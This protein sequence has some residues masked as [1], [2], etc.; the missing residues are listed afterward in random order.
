M[1][2]PVH[3]DSPFLPG[4]GVSRHFHPYW[5]GMATLARATGGSE[6]D[7]IHLGAYFSLAVLA[8]GIYAFGRSYYRSSWG[9]VALLSAMLLAWL[10]PFGHT[11]LHSIP[12]LF[13]AAAYPATLLI[14]L[15]LILW[16]L[17]IT[18]LSRMWLAALAIPLVAF[19]FATHQLGAG[20]GLVGAGAILAFW[21]ECPLQAASHRRGSHS[22]RAC[23]VLCLA[24][25]QSL[26]GRPGGRQSTVAGAAEFLQ[27]AA[28][29]D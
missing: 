5:L 8:V 1:L 24:A 3:P 20:I 25:V 16:S 9:P 17:T 18:S 26:S 2:D 19:M 7:A 4:S 23:P 13:E 10:V 27:S 11:G 22:D 21:P 14:G 29:G 6:W 28:S 15:S 12:S